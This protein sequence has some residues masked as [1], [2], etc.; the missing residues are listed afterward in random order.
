MARGGVVA[1]VLR[2]DVYWADLD[3]V[4]GHEQGGLRPVLVISPE[5]LNTPSQTPIVLAI[6]GR[7]PRAAF[8]LSSPLPGSF[9]PRPSWVKINQVRTV[10]VD[11]F[12]S[13]IGH[14]DEVEVDRIVE[15]LIEIVTG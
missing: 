3:P 8:P 2:G 12:G 1:R 4:R 9:K 14:L 5:S 13:R 6:T 11:R 7:S 15:G 10:S